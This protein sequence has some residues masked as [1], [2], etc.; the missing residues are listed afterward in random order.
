MRKKNRIL[1]RLMKPV[2]M[3]IDRI[4]PLPV[5]YLYYKYSKSKFT[6]KKDT[7]LRNNYVYN[8]DNAS[9][10]TPLWRYFHSAT[11]A[12]APFAT[13]VRFIFSSRQIRR[14]SSWN[15]VFIGLTLLHHLWRYAPAQG[16]QWGNTSNDCGRRNWKAIVFAIWCSYLSWPGPFLMGRFSVLF[17]Q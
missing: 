9:I 2:Q 14:N 16:G 15:L 8:G 6:K 7:I 12:T 4:I 5:I 17:S 11:M 1:I 13:P 10:Q 3:F